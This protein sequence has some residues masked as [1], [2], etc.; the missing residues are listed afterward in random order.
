MNLLH[1]VVSAFI[2]NY[3]AITGALSACFHFGVVLSC[4]TA[5]AGIASAVR[6]LLRRAPHRQQ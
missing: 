4:L 6:F 1:S 5:I 2:E 3:S